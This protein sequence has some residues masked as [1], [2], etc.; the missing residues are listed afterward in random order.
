MYRLTAVIVI[1]AACLIAGYS[2][3]AQHV[4]GKGAETTLKPGQVMRVHNKVITAEELIAR[5]WDFESVLKP[6]ER[7]LANSLTYLRDTSLLEI[8][9]DRQGLR[10]TEKE[11]DAETARLID[12]IKQM[13][14][15]QTRGMIPYEE[16]LKEQG[17]DKEIFENAYLRERAWVILMK[18]I[19]INYFE[20]TEPHIESKH[21]LVKTLDKANE[22]HK[23]LQAV[24]ANKLD[25]YFED[26]AV[27]HS[28]DPGAGVTRGKLPRVYENDGTLVAEA[29]EALWKLKD[30]EFSEPVKTDYGYHIFKRDRTITPVKRP[31][32]DMRS[33]LITRPDRH[34]D[35]GRFER[36]VRWTFNTQKYEV[37]RRL[38]GYDVKPNK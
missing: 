15:Q 18:R 1:A 4:P 26:L 37:E 22:L 6:H 24:A 30:G 34:D 32:Q 29:S 8:E 28:E 14:R 9:A 7:V 35:E 19:L 3:G 25:E 13:V 31:L 11:V 10:L 38:P 36:W 12:N 2:A 5:V 17:L 23:R 16:W 33:D 21:I 20:E 27:Q